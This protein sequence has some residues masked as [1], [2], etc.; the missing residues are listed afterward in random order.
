MLLGW[1]WRWGRVVVE[2]KWMFAVAGTGADPLLER[3]REM[4]LGKGRRRGCMVDFVLAVGDRE[5]QVV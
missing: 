3:G 1:G 5:K 2:Q 4:P